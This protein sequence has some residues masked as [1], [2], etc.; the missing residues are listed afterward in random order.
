MRYIV[1]LGL[2][3][4][5]ISLFI[6]TVLACRYFR[7]SHA[8]SHGRTHVVLV[9]ASIGQAWRIAEWP[10]RVGD[11]RFSAESIAVWRFDKAEAVEDD[12]VLRPAARFR[13]SR[14]WLAKFLRPPRRPDVVI[15]K[16]CSSYFPGDLAAYANSVRGW[17]KR[18]TSG[19]FQVVLATVVPVTRARAMRDPGKQ[20]SILAFNGWVRNYARAEL[21]PVLDLEA[22]LRDADSSL[23]EQFAA[24]DGSH[25]NA[26]AYA[27]L[28]RQLL[29]MLTTTRP[30]AGMKEAG[31][32]SL[33]HQ[34]PLMGS[35]HECRRP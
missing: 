24:A 23:R 27:V 14:S 11:A 8:S 22:S 16:E 9:G 4:T 6:A 3:A 2:P 10:Q 21:L 35:A 1:W 26:S 18:L 5:V 17:T 13:V 29:E 28:D 30:Q 32:R 20:D 34:T 25:L 12:I 7:A 19:G 33:A 31:R 15:L